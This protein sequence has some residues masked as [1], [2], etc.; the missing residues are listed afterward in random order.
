[1]WCVPTLDPPCQDAPRPSATPM[2]TSAPPLP[3]NADPA[4]PLNTAGHAPA[5]PLN[6]THILGRRPGPCLRLPALAGS[7]RCT[8][9]R[10]PA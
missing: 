7:G 1:M 2:A 3:L 9:V 10:C 8:G 4:L 5:V 6:G